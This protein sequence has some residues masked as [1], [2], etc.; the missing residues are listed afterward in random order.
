MRFFWLPLVLLLGCEHAPPSDE[1]VIPLQQV[2]PTAMQA[3]KKQLPDVNFEK[4][5]KVSEGTFE[6]RGKNKSGKIRDVQVTAD[7]KVLEVD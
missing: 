4:A 3:A 5:W 2:P 6:V 7:G 1:S